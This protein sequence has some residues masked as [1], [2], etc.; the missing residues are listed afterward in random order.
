[1]GSPQE[2]YT[3]TWKGVFEP[4]MLMRPLDVNSTGR[5]VSVEWNPNNLESTRRHT[6]AQLQPANCSGR[7]G[8]H[9]TLSGGPLFYR[10]DFL[11]NRLR[12]LVQYVIGGYV[13]ALNGC[14]DSGHN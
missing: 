9:H 3:R 10:I 5:R 13:Y 11:Y 7:S 2:N 12:R 6:P 8:D 1:M 14:G 4:E